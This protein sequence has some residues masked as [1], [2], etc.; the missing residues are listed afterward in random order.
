[1]YYAFSQHTFYLYTVFLLG[2]I[3]HYVTFIL[4]S[5]QTERQRRSTH[6]KPSRIKQMNSNMSWGVVQL[7][8]ETSCLFHLFNGVSWADKLCNSTEWCCTTSLAGYFMPTNV[9]FQ[10]EIK[11]CKKKPS[12]KFTL[13]DLKWTKI[14]NLAAAHVGR[15]MCHH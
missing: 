13:A 6:F 1:M 2:L 11:V 10:C 3:K 4:T 7:W 8:H 12:F 9:W 5:R 14:R 15:C